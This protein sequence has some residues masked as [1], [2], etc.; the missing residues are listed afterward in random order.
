MKTEAYF[1]ILFLTAVICALLIGVESCRAANMDDLLNAIEQIESGGNSNAVGDNGKAVGAYQIW[2][3]M[4]KEVN[5]ILGKDRYCLKDRLD[6]NK[7]REMCRIFL[8]NCKKGLSLPDLGR[9]WNGSYDGYK[10]E[11]TKKYGEKIRKILGKD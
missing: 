8:M 9:C 4:V 11:S 7:S 6:R 3:I 5:R 1:R 2:P 10:K